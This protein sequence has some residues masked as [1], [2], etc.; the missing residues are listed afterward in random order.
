MLDSDEALLIIRT[1][2]RSQKSLC[3]CWCVDLVPLVA[4]LLSCDTIFLKDTHSSSL[5]ILAWDIYSQEYLYI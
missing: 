2:T 3:L 4:D 5:D 1:L